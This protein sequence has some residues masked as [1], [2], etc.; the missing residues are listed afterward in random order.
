MIQT[1]LGLLDP[2]GLGFCHSHEHLFIRKGR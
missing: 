2:G 1:V